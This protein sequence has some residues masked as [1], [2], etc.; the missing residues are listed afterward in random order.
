MPYVL[1]PPLVRGGRTGGS[2]K[3]HIGPSGQP[4][5]RPGPWGPGQ[6]PSPKP[7]TITQ[8]RNHHLC[9]G[10]SWMASASGAVSL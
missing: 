9:P 7:G 5:H 10:W 8:A 3:R 4:D 2:V 1:T 6:E